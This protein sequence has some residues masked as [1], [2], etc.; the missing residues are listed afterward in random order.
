MK[1]Y[2]SKFAFDKDT[3]CLI[4]PKGKTMKLTFRKEEETNLRN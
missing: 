2:K 1:F 3:D 4:C